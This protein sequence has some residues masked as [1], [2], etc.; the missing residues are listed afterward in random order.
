MLMMEDQQ[1]KYIWLILRQVHSK[2]GE[3]QKA[4]D[5]LTKGFGIIKALADTD[6]EKETLIS[7]YHKSFVGLGQ[8]IYEYPKLYASGANNPE[9]MVR[10]RGMELVIEHKS[11]LLE[12]IDAS[13]D[14]FKV[15]LES[16]LDYLSCQ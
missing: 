2:L 5:Y 1:N 7:H 9:H 6:A 13:Q 15:E 12:G 16:F 4:Q 3:L 8:E 11:Q 10:E 14:A